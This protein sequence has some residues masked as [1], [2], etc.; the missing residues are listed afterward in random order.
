G[1]EETLLKLGEEQVKAGLLNPAQILEGYEG[2]INAFLDPSKR[3]KGISTGFMK[4]DEYTGGLHAGDLFIIAARPSMGKT[5]FALNIAQHVALR[6]KQ[7]VAVFSLE[8]S[9]E[10]L[11]TRMLCAAAR[12]DSQRFRM[13]YLS[14]EERRK[15]NDALQELVKAPLFIDDTAGLHLMDMHAKLRRLKSEHKLGLVIVDYLQLMTG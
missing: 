7:T 8:M 15:L 14:Q 9:K 6:N 4:L 3:V 1:A 10:S 13:G 11:L 5:A 12:V 2:G